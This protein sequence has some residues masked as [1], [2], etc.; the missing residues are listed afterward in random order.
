MTTSANG[1]PRQGRKSKAGRKERPTGDLGDM[2]IY[3]PY[4]EQ[5]YSEI[6][7]SIGTWEGVA[8]TLCDEA[9]VQRVSRKAAEKWQT[10]PQE[11]VV[12]AACSYA[13][14]NRLFFDRDFCNCKQFHPTRVDKETYLATLRGQYQPVN[15]YPWIDSE[16]EE[17]LSVAAVYICLTDKAREVLRRTAFYLYK[18]ERHERWWNHC[19][20]AGVA[21]DYV[22]EHAE[23]I[24]SEFSDSVPEVVNECISVG[25]GTYEDNPV[26]H[27]REDHPRDERRVLTQL[28]CGAWDI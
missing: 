14:R 2:G 27:G 8:N 12:L 4:W 11:Y 19:T 20:D 28:W 5:L 1:E 18:S 25:D 3:Q 16:L 13:A 22:A 10:R 24:R 7:S 17:A 6:K 15:E 21:F 26:Y 23:N 9:G